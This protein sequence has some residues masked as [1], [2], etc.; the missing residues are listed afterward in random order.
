MK[1]IRKSEYTQP[2]PIQAQSIPAALGGRDIIGIAKTGSGKTAAFLWPMLVHI[3]DQNS[4]LKGMDL[5]GLFWHLPA[6][7]TTDLQ[8]SEKIWQS[9]QYERG[10]LLWR[11]VEVGTE[12]GPGGG[13]RDCGGHSGPDDRSRQNEGTNLTRVTFL[14]LDEAD[15]MFDMG[16]EPQVR[17]SAPHQARQADFAVQCNVQEAHREAGQGC[18]DRPRSHSAGR[19]WRGQL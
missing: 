14:V 15:R 2:T 5:L 16:F 8:R 1:A 10:V 13:S 12:Q 3:M 18:T 17:Q 9:V 4:W 19:C 6:I 11:G 7:I